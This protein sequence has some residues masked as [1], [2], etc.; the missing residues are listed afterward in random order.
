VECITPEI[1]GVL[2]SIDI[3]KGEP[4][5]PTARRREL[6]TKA[7]ETAPKMILAQRKL[8]RA[9]KRNLYYAD[10]QWEAPW[11][12]ATA[13]FMQDGYLDV[14]QRAA[15]FQYAYSSAPAMVMRTIGAGSK[16]PFTIRDRDGQILNGSHTYR[17]HVPANVPA[18]L[19]WATTVYNVTDGTM[20]ETAQLLPSRNGLEN[21]VMNADGSLDM[22]FGPARPDGI[23]GSNFIQTVD[24]RDFLVCFRLYGAGIEFYDQSWKLNDVEKVS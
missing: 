6:L 9:D 1:R 13:E 22:W 23:A 24:G 3:V 16:Y 2:A 11:S 12:G 15:F 8:G 19:F 21:T 18:H 4:F 17:L 10:R 5:N 7:V 20:P 14:N